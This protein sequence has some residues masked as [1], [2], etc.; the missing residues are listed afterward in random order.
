[1]H[2]LRTELRLVLFSGHRGNCSAK[3]SSFSS[4]ATSTT[5][6]ESSSSELDTGVPGDRAG[7]AASTLH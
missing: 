4:W 1:M 6:P 3:R 2:F 5:L 7:A